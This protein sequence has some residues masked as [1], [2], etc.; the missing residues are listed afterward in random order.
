MAVA[1]AQWT[2]RLAESSD[3]KKDVLGLLGDVSGVDVF[4][5][6]VLVATYIRPEKIGSIIRPQANVQEDLFQGKAGLVV[7]KGDAAFVDDGQTKF[8]GFDPEVGEYIVYRRSDAWDMTIRGVPCA[9]IPDARVKLRVD[10][11]ALVF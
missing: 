5:N 10:D 4:P 7:K 2:Q 6:Y 3:F 11:P 8:Y 1:I 9:L